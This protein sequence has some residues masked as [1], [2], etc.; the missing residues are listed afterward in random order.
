MSSE[1]ST[2]SAS[3]SIHVA[4]APPSSAASSAGT[5]IDHRRALTPLAAVAD[6]WRSTWSDL[7][8]KTRVG[9]A[10]ILNGHVLPEFGARPIGRIDSA[11]IQAFVNSKAASELAPNTVRRIYDVV[12][13][14]L[15]VAV[16]RRYIATNPCD[17]V[18]L[19]RKAQRELAIAP[20]SHPEVRALV[21]A[22]PARDQL[23]VLLDAYT[24]LRSGELWA[25]RR[26]SIDLLHG[27]LS[28]NEAIKEVTTEEAA[29]VPPANRLSPSLIIGPTKT[30]AA[31]K[32]SIPAFLRPLLAD[33]LARPLPGGTGPDAFIFTGPTG[34]PRRHNQWY[35][36]VFAPAAQATRPKQPPRFHDL[37]HTCAALLIL[38]GAHPLEIKL[39]LGH[40]DIRTTM[41]T[42]GHLFPSA[43]AAL[44]DL[45]D[46][47]YRAAEQAPAVTAIRG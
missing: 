17:A 44:A 26:R 19:P 16:E 15:R 14:V 46:T 42:Y 22:L 7:E 3:A 5:H 12:R 25:L 31:R 40:E 28:V 9:Y 2:T 30:H 27:E 36:R 45:L 1:P 6:E 24:G 8:P 10:S 34:A 47:G 41:N 39:R 23:A 18:R 21:A 35:K 33:H 29:A 4:S 20:L 38:A 11:A 43:E 32:V 37:R 13:N